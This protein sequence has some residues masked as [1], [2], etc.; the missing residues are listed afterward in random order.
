MGLMVGTHMH[1]KRNTY[2]CM[3]FIVLADNPPDYDSLD[4]QA[5]S[6][7]ALGALVTTVVNNCMRDADTFATGTFHDPSICPDV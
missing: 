6:T 4:G 1:L 2:P 3:P 5:F 7:G